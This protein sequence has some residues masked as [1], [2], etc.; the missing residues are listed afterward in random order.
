MHLAKRDVVLWLRHLAERGIH[1]TP[2]AAA[3]RPSTR[4][5]KT[6]LA[7]GLVR[8]RMTDEM[9]SAQVHEPSTYRKRPIL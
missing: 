4:T 8:C 2:G 6:R 1:V 9:E 7:F 5:T 3:V